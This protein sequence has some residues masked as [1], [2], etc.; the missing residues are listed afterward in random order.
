MTIGHRRFG[1]GLAGVNGWGDIRKINSIDH[2][3]CFFFFIVVFTRS[4]R[5]LTTP[6]CGF[7]TAHI[8]KR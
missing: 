8:E 3:V 1:N 4:V 6:C 2:S 7:R 5:N